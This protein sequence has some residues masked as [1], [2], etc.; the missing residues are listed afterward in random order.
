MGK[1]AQMHSDHI[2]VTS[3]NP[4]SEEPQ[5]IINDILQGVDVSK[6]VIIEADRLKAIQLALTM[7]QVGDVILVAGKGHENYQ[8]V[9]GVK[10]PFDDLKIIKGFWG[11]SS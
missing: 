11:L 2:V 3:D 5:N 10:L 7:A 4:R 6:S 9:N 8:E 1:I